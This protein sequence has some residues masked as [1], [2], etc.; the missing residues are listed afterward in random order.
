MGV[1][2]TTRMSSKGQIVIPENIRKKLNLKE[3]TQFV[4][5]GENDVVMLKTIEAPI[6]GSFDNLIQEAH[7]QA[8][9]AGLKQSDIKAAI[10]KAREHS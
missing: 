7:A 8:K 4:V 9:I 2:A 3:G 1:L 5:V 10:K 6:I